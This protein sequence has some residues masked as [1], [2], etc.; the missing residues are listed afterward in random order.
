MSEL[1]VHDSPNGNA[2]AYV[3]QDDRVA[4]LYL[5]GDETS[6]LGVRS[7]WVRNLAPAP[8][9]VDVE[10]MKRGEAPLLPRAHCRHPGGAPPLE[11]GGLRIVWLEEGDAAALLQGDELLA[12]I[13]G[14]SG[15]GGFHGY[16][17]D[18]VGQSPL[19]WE[20]GPEN[21]MHERVRRAEEAWAAWDAEPGPWPPLQEAATAALAAQLGPYSNYYAIDG[22]AWPPTAMVRIPVREG[23]A[24]VTVGMCQRPQPVVERVHAD[25]APYRR[26]ELGI[27]VSS[28]VDAGLQRR[29]SE[30]MAGQARLPWVKHTWL[31]DGH[32]IPCSAFGG[33]SP[34]AA[35]LLLARPPE[36]PVLS[37]PTHRGDPVT[38]LWMVPITAA[39]RELAMR[40]GSGSL[41]RRLAGEGRGWMYRPPR[42]GWRSRFGR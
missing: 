28:E 36:A 7:C 38:V 33:E 19:A 25:P 11:P 39:E 6:G 18:C 2:Q 26:I 42:R 16:A 27:C 4:Y 24:F 5:A 31:G 41:V 3:E 1:L 17:R 8:D 40:E 34:M 29:L 15:H 9:D 23:A 20:L 13:P 10:A 32:T 21:A 35:V 30:Y 22:G 12:V 37:L 14:W